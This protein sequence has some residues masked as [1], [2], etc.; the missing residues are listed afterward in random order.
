LI[1]SKLAAIEVE[2]G[3]VKVYGDTVTQYN[4]ILAN[5]AAT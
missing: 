4:G 2:G 3:R 5:L 1:N